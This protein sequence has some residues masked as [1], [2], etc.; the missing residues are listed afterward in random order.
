[1]ELHS[2]DERSSDLSWA[3][4][5]RGSSSATGVVISVEKPCMEAAGIEPA[6]DSDR[7]VGIEGPLEC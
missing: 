7:L 1:V 3:R 4:L 2:S 6:N 5:N